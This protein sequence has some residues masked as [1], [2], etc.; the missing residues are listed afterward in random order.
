MLAGDSILRGRVLRAA[1]MLVDWSQAR[2]ASEA[3]ISRAAVNAVETGRM[4]G[5]SPAG[6]AMVQALERA[7]VQFIPPIGKLGPGLRFTPPAP[8]S[9]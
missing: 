8:P 1:R 3:C 9:R 6:T 4:N 7:G 2:L 5:D